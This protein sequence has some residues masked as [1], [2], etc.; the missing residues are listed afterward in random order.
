MRGKDKCAILKSIRIRLAELNHIS[1]SPHPCE[2]KGDCPGTCEACDA[3]SQWLLMTLKSMEEKGFPV[4]Y[5]LY[6]T[7]QLDVDKEKIESNC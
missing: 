2:N 5:S 6:D 3:E 4:I 7:D 1:Y